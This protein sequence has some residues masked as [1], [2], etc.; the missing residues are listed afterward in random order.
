LRL[1][2]GGDEDIGLLELGAQST[3]TCAYT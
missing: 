1:A 3:Q 2:D